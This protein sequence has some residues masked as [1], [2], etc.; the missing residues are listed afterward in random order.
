MSI[1]KLGKGLVILASATFLFACAS[2]GQEETQ[3]VTPPV[4]ETT[5]TTIDTPPP[6]SA[7]E[8]AAEANAETR[9]AR[10]V[11]F[12]LDDDTVSSEG[13][14]LLEAH[15]WFLAKNPSVV[16]TVDGHCDERGTPAYNL[17][18]GERR[19]KAVAQILMLNGVSSSQIKTVSHGEEQ[20]A[21]QGHDE[22]AWSKNRRGELSYDG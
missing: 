3:T 15:A 1:T 2:D 7:E 11:Y 21:V 10:T 13:R 5:T 20:P 12:D 19:A 16:I 18:L 6:K 14:A 8:L 4:E 9:K 17:A 22:S